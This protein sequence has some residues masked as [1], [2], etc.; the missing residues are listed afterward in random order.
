MPIFRVL[1][2]DSQHISVSAVNF[3]NS[4]NRLAFSVGLI[5]QMSPL[6]HAKSLCGDFIYCESIFGDMGFSVV[7]CL[8]EGDR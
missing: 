6:N 2:M 7:P 8:R 1:Q 5:A 3:S 4:G